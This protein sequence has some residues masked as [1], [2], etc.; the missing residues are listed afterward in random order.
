MPMHYGKKMGKKKNP[1]KKARKMKMKKM[2]MKRKK[3]WNG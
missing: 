2:G 3:R 1:M